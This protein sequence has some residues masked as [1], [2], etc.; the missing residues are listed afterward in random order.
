MFDILLLILAFVFLVFGL[1]G[2]LNFAKPCRNWKVVAKARVVSKIKYFSAVGVYLI[3]VLF[4]IVKMNVDK[5]FSNLECSLFGCDGSYWYS[6]DLESL[7][8]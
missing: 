3:V 5:G 1:L 8:G 6:L 7:K 2:L 4:F